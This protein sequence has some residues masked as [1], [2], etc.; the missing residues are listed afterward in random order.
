MSDNNPLRFTTHEHI[1]PDEGVMLFWI[2]DNERERCACFVRRTTCVFVAEQ[3]NKGS[4]EL[5][6]LEWE[7]E[8]R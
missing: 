7:L 5:E 8:Q 2:R 3:L 4:M 1:D 6:D